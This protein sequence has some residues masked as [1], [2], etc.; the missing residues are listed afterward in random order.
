[1]FSQS[2]QLFK[3]I[4]INM[5]PMPFWKL[6]KENESIFHHIELARKED[7]WKGD[8]HRSIAAHPIGALAYKIP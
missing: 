3:Y 1:M 5:V 4:K 8:F 2:P 7:R 6:S